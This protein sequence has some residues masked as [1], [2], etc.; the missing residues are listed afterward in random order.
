MAAL[1]AYCIHTFRHSDDL[2]K[3]EQEGGPGK[4]TERKAWVT[5]HQLWTAALRGG[6]QVPVLFSAAD[7]DSVLTHWAVIDEI[8]IDEATRHTT[9]SYS[10]L[11]PI[12]QPRRLSELRLRS[13]DRNLSDDLIRPYAICHTPGFLA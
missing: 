8:F 3:Q 12:A 4:L 1:Y 10:S 9:C 6:E 13:G 11:R 2:R 5:G 7:V